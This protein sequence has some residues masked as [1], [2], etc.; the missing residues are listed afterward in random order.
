MRF[1]PGGISSFIK[2]PVNELCGKAVD[3]NCLL[4]KSGAIFEER[5]LNAQTIEE[6]LILLQNFLFQKMFNLQ[7]FDCLIEDFVRKITSFY[8]NYSI[9]K[10]SDESKISARQLRRRFLHSVG[11]SPKRFSRI[12]RFQ[13]ALCL[14]KLNKINNLT[15]LVYKSNY[16]DQSHFIRDFKE[17]TGSSPKSYLT[18]THKFTDLIMR[19]G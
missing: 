3:L 8:G 15:T 18:K 6:R 19:N 17:F 9:E 12:V 1:L 7:R 2:T 16:F 4:G 14:I 5:I 11:I 10:F 13:N